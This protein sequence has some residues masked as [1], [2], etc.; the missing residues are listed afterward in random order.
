MTNMNPNIEW[1]RQ[2]AAIEDE[3]LVSVGGLV[4]RLEEPAKITSAADQEESTTRSQPLRSHSNPSIEWLRQKAAIED[5]NLTSIGGL[6]S[7]LHGL[8]Q[9]TG[10]ETPPNLPWHDTR[11]FAELRLGYLKQLMK[12]LSASESI[13]PEQRCDL[14]R[15]FVMPSVICVESGSTVA[16]V[17]SALMER[18]R[19]FLSGEPGAGKTCLLRF[20]ALDAA[21]HFKSGLTD[22]LPVYLSM[23]EWTADKSFE[24]FL[25]HTISQFGAPHLRE[26]FTTRWKEGGLT[27]FLDG[28]DEVLDQHR[29]VVLSEIQKA[30]AIGTKCRFFISSRSKEDSHTLR[31]FENYEI[32]APS[33]WQRLQMV[34]SKFKE[35]TTAHAFWTRLQAETD[36]HAPASNP[37]LL[38]LLAARYGRNELNPHDISNVLAQIV[39][40]LVDEWDATRGIV[41]SRESWAAPNQKLALLK[42]VAAELVSRDQ[43]VFSLDDFTTW[44]ERLAG[45]HDY[46]RILDRLV[47]HTGLLQRVSNVHWAF[48]HAVY[49]DFLA[50]SFSVEKCSGVEEYQRTCVH[51]ATYRRSFRFLCGRASDATD[52]VSLLSGRGAR[53]TWENA[54]IL[55]E[56]LSQNLSIDKAATEY[57]CSYIIRVLEDLVK[58]ESA[59]RQ[60]VTVETVR[61]GEQSFELNYPDTNPQSIQTAEATSE[62]LNALSKARD[63][64]AKAHFAANM[65]RSTVPL[66]KDIGVTFGKGARLTTALSQR[67]TRLWIQSF[68]PDEDCPDVGGCEGIEIQSLEESAFC[69]ES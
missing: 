18:P 8:A 19:V 3:S 66:V 21:H 59:S 9:A 16:A 43:Q 13:L 38:T 42:R 47:E 60:G 11:H 46:S 20:L 51:P 53:P 27:L 32:A 36:L 17:M 48:S 23:R 62:L 65:E 50:A 49:R 29:P 1:L 61:K 31:N 55:A 25:H 5:E 39:D 28:L 58:A 33:T 67:K 44:L 26:Q 69:I 68:E 30:T 34:K 54:V 37:L 45:S 24:G 2:K 35:A 64:I 7:R 10:A 41:R 6:P 63:G 57:A 22:N 15:K 14:R 52:M 12:L 4:S 56:A 40:T